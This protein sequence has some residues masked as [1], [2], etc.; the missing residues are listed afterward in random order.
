M[1]VAFWIPL[2]REKWLKLE[3]PESCVSD[4]SIMGTLGSIIAI[5]TVVNG[6]SEPRYGV[7]RLNRDRIDLSEWVIHF[8]H[9]RDSSHYPKDVDLPLPF[10]FDK[11]GKPLIHDLDRIAYDDSDRL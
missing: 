2:L 5:N 8:V 1:L 4:R 6:K 9:D 3:V 10:C 7:F 11:T